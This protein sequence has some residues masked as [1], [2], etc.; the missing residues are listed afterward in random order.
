PVRDDLGF[1]PVR[2]TRGR[3]LPFTPEFGSKGSLRLAMKRS[4]RRNVDPPPAPNARGI[5][6]CPCPCSI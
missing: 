6:S 5:A 4:A 2:K 1:Q 3:L